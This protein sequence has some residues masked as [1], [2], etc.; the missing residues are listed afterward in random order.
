MH[1]QTTKAEAAAAWEPPAAFS[2]TGGLS[3]AAAQGAATAQNLGGG[4]P[5]CPHCHRGIHTWVWLKALLLQ[6]LAAGRAGAEPGLA[7]WKHISGIKHTRASID[8]KNCDQ[9]QRVKVH[10]LVSCH[11]WNTA[12][13]FPL[14]LPSQP[15]S[16]PLFSLWEE[17]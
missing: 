12:S 16:P 5:C 1:Q 15:L 13:N 8:H 11:S 3:S 9:A 14:Y 2:S 17:G 6:P 10:E 7:S 4:G